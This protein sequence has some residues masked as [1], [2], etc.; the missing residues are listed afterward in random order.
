M[1]TRKGSKRHICFVKL[2]FTHQCELL[3]L[4][5][6]QFDGASLSEFS[7]FTDVCPVLSNKNLTSSPQAFLYCS[8][9]FRDTG[10]QLPLN[11]MN[12]P[13]NIEIQA[14]LYVTI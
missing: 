1:K 6:A 9:G 4:I 2:R 7:C 3:Q 10:Q 11:I 14:A 13:G 12:D 8:G 5:T